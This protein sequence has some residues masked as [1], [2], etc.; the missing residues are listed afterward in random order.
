MLQLNQDKIHHNLG[1]S[2]EKLKLIVATI[3]DHFTEFRL[4][5]VSSA[6][7]GQEDFLKVISDYYSECSELYLDALQKS[8]KNF[9]SVEPDVLRML[10][11]SYFTAIFEVVERDYPREMADACIAPLFK[12][13]QSGWDALTH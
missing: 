4:L 2:L 6:G 3:Y 5:M 10:S 12:F 7:S 11:Y 8:G 1:I 13:F 9:I